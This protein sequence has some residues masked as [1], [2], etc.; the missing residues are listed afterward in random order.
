MAKQDIPSSVNQFKTSPKNHIRFPDPILVILAVVIFS[1]LVYMAYSMFTFLSLIAIL[2][3]GS[4][5]FFNIL[6]KVRSEEKNYSYGKKNASFYSIIILILPFIFG[7]IIALDGYLN[8]MTITQA[9]FVWT[10]TL[11]FWQTMLFV[12][13]AIRSKYRDSIMHLND[14]IKS[15]DYLYTIFSF[16]YRNPSKFEVLA[17]MLK[18]RYFPEQLIQ[19]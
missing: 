6:V 8:L 12:P 15:G 14:E 1:L 2:F 4:L 19:I 16:V 13:L 7:T 10:L 11:S 18:H 9:I 17:C 5:A 3:A